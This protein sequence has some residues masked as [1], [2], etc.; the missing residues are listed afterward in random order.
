MQPK[1]RVRSEHEAVKW[2]GYSSFEPG[3][4]YRFP[5]ALRFELAP[6]TE[7]SRE[8][9][10]EEALHRT[11][12]IL[13]DLDMGS[14]RVGIAAQIYIDD[15]PGEL[16]RAARTLVREMRAIGIHI[17]KPLSHI[18]VRE[19]LD[20]SVPE[21]NPLKSLVVFIDANPIGAPSIEWL[22]RVFG[23]DHGRLYGT[24]PGNWYGFNLDRKVLVHPY[25]DRGLD[26][27]ALNRDGLVDLYNKRNGWLLNYDRARMDAVFG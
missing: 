7:D 24:P 16:A 21:T 22:R 5:N 8:R 9:C 12:A 17:Y 1:P 2:F 3:L 18:I 11:I 6:K 27:I 14:G 20:D 23:D 25:D 13:T 26:V 4:F 19:A 10:I 15:A